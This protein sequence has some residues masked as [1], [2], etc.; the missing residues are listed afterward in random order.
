VL[1]AFISKVYISER[2][3]ETNTQSVQIEYNFIGIFDFGTAI[4]KAN[5]PQ[6]AETAGV[7]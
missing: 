1:R 6:D 5:N 2:D 4:E 7:A 3:K